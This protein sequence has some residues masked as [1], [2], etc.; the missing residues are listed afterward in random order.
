M[1][2]KESVQQSK[3]IQAI[4]NQFRIAM[5]VFS[6]FLISCGNNA[7]YNNIQSEQDLLR[8]IATFTSDSLVQVVIEIPA[9]TNEKW[10]VNKTTG[11][12]EWEVLKNGEKRMIRYLGYPANYGFIPQTVVDKSTGG[13]GDPADVFVLGPAIARGSIVAVKLIGMINMRDNNE[14]DP[15]L[16]AVCADDTIF[17]IN[18]LQELMDNHPGIIEIIKLWLVHYKGPNHVEIVSEGDEEAALRYISEA[19]NTFIND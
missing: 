7:S 15:K 13:D 14:A 3:L 19:H 6:A 9:G 4:N 12:L 8:D 17:N 5:L 16:L 18:S 1:K 11:R 2:Q 10:E